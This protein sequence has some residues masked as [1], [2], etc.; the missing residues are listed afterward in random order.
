MFS[1]VFHVG[2]GDY[3]I[4]YLVHRET[5]DEI[6]AQINAETVPAFITFRDSA[7]RECGIATRSVLAYT[8][9]GEKLF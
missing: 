3:E 5:V 7:G 8:I 4:E 6:L 2:T 9:K 1:A